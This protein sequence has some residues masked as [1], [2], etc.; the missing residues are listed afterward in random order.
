[1][2][3]LDNLQRLSEVESKSLFSIKE[4]K[5]ASEAVGIPKNKFGS[6]LQSLNLQG[7]LLNRGREMYQLNSAYL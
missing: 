4:I 5:Q 7:F 6:T 2:K 1:M 3:L